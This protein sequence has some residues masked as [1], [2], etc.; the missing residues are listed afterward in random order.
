MHTISSHQVA[1]LEQTVE[2]LEAEGRLRQA[3]WKGHKAELQGQ[4]R[5]GGGG[6]RE[7]QGKAMRGKGGAEAAGK[8][9]AHT[10]RPAGMGVAYP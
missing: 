9:E 5:R 6:A 2:G 1:S 3:E 7:L 4:V 10:W 8:E